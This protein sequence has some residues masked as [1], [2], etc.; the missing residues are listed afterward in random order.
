MLIIKKITAY[1]KIINIMLKGFTVT[2]LP[3][4]NR[5]QNLKTNKF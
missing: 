2:G 1:E 5:K 4:K 3:Y